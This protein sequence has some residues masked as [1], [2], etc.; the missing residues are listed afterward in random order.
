M[1]I[2]KGHTNWLLNNIINLMQ[3]HI[4]EL[5]RY[6]S[7]AVRIDQSYKQSCKHVQAVFEPTDVLTTSSVLQ[8]DSNRGKHE[9][10][11]EWIEF[12]ELL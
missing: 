1:K 8:E 4:Y 3:L 9:H 6:I 2:K 11:S 5:V 10:N 7:Q 12:L